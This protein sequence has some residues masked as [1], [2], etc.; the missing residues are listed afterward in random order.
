MRAYF[1]FVLHTGD[2][3]LERVSPGVV[4]LDPPEKLVIETRASGGYGQ[5]DWQRNGVGFGT[6]PFIVTLQEFPN[7]FEIFVREP[8]NTNDLGLYEAEA[9]QEIDFTVTPYSK[10]MYVI[11]CVV[12]DARFLLTAYCHNYT[13]I[14]C[15]S[16]F[17][18]VFSWVERKI[19]VAFPK[20]SSMSPKGQIL[21]C[22]G[23]VTYFLDGTSNNTL[24]HPVS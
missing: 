10:Y 18:P 5:F 19:N 13:E 24:P 9:G 20:Q 2:V 22:L 17:I 4:V 14:F 8:T 16:I 12:F 21:F 11:S 15:M 3:M 7:F 6:S 1:T 23:N